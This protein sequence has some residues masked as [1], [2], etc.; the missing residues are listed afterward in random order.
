MRKGS[1]KGVGRKSPSAA[2]N[3]RRQSPSFTKSPIP[4]SGRTPKSPVAG[5]QTKSPVAGQRVGRKSPS[6]SG[7]GALDDG[8]QRQR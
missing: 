7:R 2:A 3:K 5:R 6:V 4:G 1:L 8:E